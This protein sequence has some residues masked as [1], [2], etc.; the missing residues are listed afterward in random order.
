MKTRSGAKNA[1][2]HARPPARLAGYVCDSISDDPPS[3]LARVCILQTSSCESVISLASAHA[4]MYESAY[5]TGIAALFRYA[6]VS[7][8]KLDEAFVD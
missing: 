4:R 5:Q 2:K 8:A 1:V 6:D 7:Q 3:L